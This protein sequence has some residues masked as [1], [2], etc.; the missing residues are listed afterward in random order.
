MDVVRH[1]HEP[2]TSRRE[3]VQSFTKPSQQDS[4]GL[5]VIKQPPSSID[6]KGYEVDIKL[7]VDYAPL[8][9]HAS[10]DAVSR[11]GPQPLVPAGRDTGN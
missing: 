11:A 6:R 2:H 3:L 7:V 1:D 5:V 4:L 9:Y 10:N 8:D